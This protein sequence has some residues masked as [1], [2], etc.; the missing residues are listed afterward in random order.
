MSGFCN[1]GRNFIHETAKFA[2]LQKFYIALENLRLYGTL[3]Q[4]ISIEIFGTY[5]NIQKIWMS[6]RES[7]KKKEVTLHLQSDITGKEPRPLE[8]VKLWLYQFFT[9]N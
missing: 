5:N 1:S 2:N 6:R 7:R 8:V 9:D 4:V 3:E